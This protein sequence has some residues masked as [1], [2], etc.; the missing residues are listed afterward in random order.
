MIQIKIN[1]IEGYYYIEDG[2]LIYYYE[3]FQTKE[4]VQVSDLT[5]MKVYQ[6]NQLASSI[7]EAYP[8]FSIK[9]LKGRFI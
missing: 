1:D 4:H 8:T 5:D 2:E 9:V 3:D 7:N 6:Y